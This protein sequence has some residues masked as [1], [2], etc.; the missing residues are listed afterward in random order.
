LLIIDDCSTDNTK[1]VLCSLESIDSRIK[2]FYSEKNSGAGNS[3]NIGLSHSIGQYIAFLDSDDLWLPQKLE[4]QIK[5]MRNCCAPICHTSFSFIDENGSSRKGAVKV[6]KKVG[7]I[8]NLKKT[9]IGTSTAMIDR[10][11]VGN[12]FRFSHIRARQDIKLWIELL[13]RG[14]SSYGLDEPLV[15]YR[16]RSGSVSSNK[17]KMLSA[18]LKVYMGVTSLSLFERLSCYCS[19][20]YNAIKKRQS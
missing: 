16:V 2:C 1:E 6:S 5:Y 3:R 13:S 17:F 10:F 8:D 14:I 7:L 18:T 12:D 15:K 11:I 19:Y 20:V 9:E 4:L